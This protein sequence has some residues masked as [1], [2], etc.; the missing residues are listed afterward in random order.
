MHQETA[1]QR[2]LFS[3]KRAT[4]GM[5]CVSPGFQAHEKAFLLVSYP[6]FDFCSESMSETTRKGIL[7]RLF[8]FP[9]RE[10]NIECNANLACGARSGQDRQ[11]TQHS[12]HHFAVVMLEKPLEVL[13]SKW[14]RKKFNPSCSSTLAN[15]H[16]PRAPL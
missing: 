5:P 4:L 1:V 8:L 15:A 9:V 2:M 14:Q 3:R 16:R 10:P 6:T 11:D 7:K 12:H 13:H